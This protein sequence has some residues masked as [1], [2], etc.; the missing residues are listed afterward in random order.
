M[1]NNQFP[2]HFCEEKYYTREATLADTAALMSS[3]DYKERFMAEYDQT[4]IC[5]NKL[6]TMIEK[7]DNDA[8]EFTPTC[9]RSTYDMQL[10]ARNDNDYV[11]E[12][13]TKWS[14]IPIGVFSS[15]IEFVCA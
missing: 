14:I 11:L 3:T 4:A 5:Y 10:S 6:A 8:L 2:I 7:W 1:S 15:N 13:S 12:P 9:P